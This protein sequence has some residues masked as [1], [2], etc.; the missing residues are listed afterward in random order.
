MLWAILLSLKADN[1][2]SQIERRAGVKSAVQ[3]ARA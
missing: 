3:L 2:G 1:G